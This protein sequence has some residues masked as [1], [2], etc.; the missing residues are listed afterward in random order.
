MALS[1]QIIRELRTLFFSVDR[2][3]VI[4]GD[5]NPQTTETYGLGS[6][7]KKWDTIY[8]KDLYADSITGGAPG[9]GDADT[10][11]GFHADASPTSGMLL[12][13]DINAEFPETVYIEALLK[14]GS[15]TLEDDLAVVAGKTIDNVDIGLHDHSGVYGSIVI[16][17]SSL[18]GL[19]ADDHPQYTQWAQEE[20]IIENWTFTNT[21]DAIDA[22]YKYIGWE[23]DTIVVLDGNNEPVPGSTY[24]SLK[25]IPFTGAD[26]GALMEV[27]VGASGGTGYIVGDTPIIT[28]GGG[29]GQ[30]R[31]D[32]ESSGVVTAIS[33]YVIDDSYSVSSDNATTGGTGSG[34]LVDIDRV[35]IQSYD[36][37]HEIEI[38]TSGLESYISIGSSGGILLKDDESDTFIQVG[39]ASELNLYGTGSYRLWSG[40]VTP[41]S[42]PFSVTDAGHVVMTSA[43][44]GGWAVD[45]DSITSNGIDIKSAG[46]IVI[47]SGDNAITLSA[48]DVT[49]SPGPYLMWAGDA[50]ASNS[51]FKITETG[52]VYLANAIIDGQLRSVNYQ[53][54]PP[55][56]G[57][58]LSQDGTLTAHNIIARGRIEAVVYRET[59]ISAISG[60]MLLTPAAILAVDLADTDVIMVVDDVVFQSSDICRLKTITGDEWVKVTSDYT[61]V[62]EGFQ[63]SI[64]RDYADLGASYDY[65]IGDTVIRYG[66][67]IQPQAPLP[68]ASGEE[69]AVLGSYQPAGSLATTQGGWLTLLGSRGDGPFFG[70][71]ARTGVTYDAYEEVVRIG[72]LNTILDY[73]EETWGLF[74]GKSTSY[75]AFDDVQG[76]RINAGDGNTTIDDGGIFTDIFGVERLEAKPDYTDNYATLYF[77]DTGSVRELRAKMKDGGDEY[78]VLITDEDDP[79]AT[80]I[81]RLIAISGG[82]LTLDVSG[83]IDVAPENGI[84]SYYIDTYLSASSDTLVDITGG[85]DGDILIISP[86]NG[87]RTIIV[88]AFTGNIFTPN[89]ESIYL[90][91]VFQ[92]LILKRQAGDWWVVSHVNKATS[93]TQG[94]VELAIGSEVDTGTD[95]TRAVTPEALTDSEYFKAS[96]NRKLDSALSVD[97]TASGD[98]ITYQVDV[99]AFGFG[100]TLR[101][102]TGGDLRTADA[103]GITSV[104]CIA[105]ALEAGTGVKNVLLRGLIRDDTWSWVTGGEASLIYLSNTLGGMTQTQPSGTGDQVQVLGYALSA[106]IMMFA[107]SL[108]LVEVD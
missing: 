20:V 65:L 68:I 62:A 83:A 34:L 42:A 6:A 1:P 96:E 45:S 15:R 55:G 89:S 58:L 76:L 31:V 43:D 28:G 2:N 85:Q 87:S 102:D 103:D 79:I 88:E 47:G 23:F 57:W 38:R 9:G 29:L 106:T 19:T 97:H 86:Q 64:T 78:D 66:S 56:K 12:P 82:G 30:V 59:E 77:Y 22:Y 54:G 41:A 53:A 75:M 14:D 92:M 13:L 4:S 93:T 33:V 105:L 27:S 7:G 63:Y 81:D 61:V 51:T 101:V 60:N 24:T 90:D 26:A 32:A 36:H 3:A 100:A 18:G 67:A 98:T 72:N 73:T 94:T 44:I 95:A 80:K 46:E 48:I 10:V 70:V 16:T 5:I 17:H 40:H 25:S 108:V 104:P 37:S 50:V 8:V 71:T 84:G 35:T 39:G 107:P 91:D 99:N 21:A 69:D 74:V 49:G 11:D 52:I